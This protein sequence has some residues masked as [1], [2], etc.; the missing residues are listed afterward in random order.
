MLYHLSRLTKTYERRTV[1]DIPE[2][3]LEA[4]RIY[5]LLGPNG[6]GKTTLMEILAFLL[7][8]TSGEVVFESRR[9]DY[10]ELGLQRLRRDVILVPQTPILFS[11][12]V[13]KNVEFGLKVRRTPRPQREKIV[14]EVLDLVG[15]RQFWDS[16]AQTL[17]GGETQRV[18]IARALACEPRVLLFDEPTANVDLENQF[19]IEAIIR[20]INAEKKISMV[21]TSHNMLQAASLAHH[22]ISLMEGKLGTSAYENIYSGVTGTDGTG[23]T[24]CEITGGIRVPV[25][26][27]QTGRV[28]VWLDPKAI[29]LRSSSQ[30]PTLDNGWTGRIVQIVDESDQVRMV[31]DVGV[32]LS[33]LQSRTDYLQ[34][35]FLV[36]SVV[37]LIFRPEAVHLI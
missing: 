10:S 37:K 16:P 17:S 21:L 3:D 11:T 31:V 5:A 32:R 1:L 20:S 19:T 36:G 25:Q 33:V 13:F 24:F 23:N 14:H 28:K 35:P 26:A 34:E 9:V 4:E 18:A 29:L 15:M 30:P 7:P 12:T 22:V 2:L 8:P 6:A 27:S